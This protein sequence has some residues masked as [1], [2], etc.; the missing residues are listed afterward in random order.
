MLGL[1]VRAW[2]RGLAAAARVIALVRDQAHR[3]HLIDCPEEARPPATPAA[4]RDDSR[5]A[6]DPR[7]Y[8]QSPPDPEGA[9]VR[10]ARVPAFRSV[11]ALDGP[12]PSENREQF[13]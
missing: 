9:K 5:S 3:M 2:A 7:D 12:S 6:S 11:V 13:A 1:A 4:C 8:A 10:G